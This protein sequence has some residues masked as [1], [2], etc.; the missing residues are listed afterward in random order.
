LLIQKSYRLRANRKDLRIKDL[1]FDL[2]DAPGR[3]G[4]QTRKELK[5]ETD[6]RVPSGEWNGFY[7][8]DRPQ[9]GWMHLYMSFKEGRIQ[10]EGTDYV[11]PWTAGGWY[12]LE[13]GTC[14]WVKNYVGRHNVSYEGQITDRGI[15]GQWT[16]LTSGTFHIWPRRF[17]ELNELYLKQDLEAPVGPSPLVPSQRAVS[18]ARNSATE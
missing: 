3:S 10:G 12:D 9:R 11:G 17:H 16:I 15:L 6:N 7:L 18:S 14:G 5:M 1:C 8:E 2:K 13:L 4:R